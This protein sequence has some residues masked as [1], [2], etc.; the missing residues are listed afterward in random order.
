MIHNMRSPEKPAIA[1]A[2]FTASK[3]LGTSQV[4]KPTQ[5]GESANFLKQTE[6]SFWK[7]SESKV[8]LPSFLTEDK[9]RHMLTKYDGTVPIVE[10][11]PA[12]KDESGPYFSLTPYDFDSREE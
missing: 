3:N 11:S 5:Y 1:A 7:G 10:L 6:Q 12:P 4:T 2:F 8:E 9:P